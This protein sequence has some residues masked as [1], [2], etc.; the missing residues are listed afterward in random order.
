MDFGY[1][2]ARTDQ[3]LG[4]DYQSVKDAEAEKGPIGSMPKTDGSQYEQ[5]NPKAPPQLGAVAQHGVLH[6]N[7]NPLRERHVP[8]APKIPKTLYPVW[9]VE[10]FNQVNPEQACRSNGDIRVA[11]EVA[12]NLNP[13]EDERHKDL[14]PIGYGQIHEDIIDKDTHIVGDYQLFEESQGNLIETVADVFHA[15][16]DFAFE[17]GYE[18]RR[19]LYGPGNQLREK[20]HVEGKVAKV[21]LRFRIAIVN[22][23]RVAQRLKGVKGNTQGEQD[24]MCDGHI[25]DPQLGHHLMDIDA[26]KSEILE[27]K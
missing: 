9:P 1:A 11:A 5:I 18:V 12:K 27:V 16:L 25:G 26:E 3:V 4:A 10:V 6:V 8:S 19:A 21:P 7:E 24:V 22:I 13:E 15:Q 2:R 20:G 17:L 14:Q 23:E